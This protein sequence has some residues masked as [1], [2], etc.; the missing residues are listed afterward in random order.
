MKSVIEI[1]DALNLDRRF[2][3][4]L[5]LEWHQSMASFPASGLDFLESEFYAKQLSAAGISVALR[6]LLDDVANQIKSS[7][8]LQ[9]LAWHAHHYLCYSETMPS[10]T[11]WPELE[12]IF[13]FNCGLFYLL[14]GL[15][16]IPVFSRTFRKLGL[17]T[18]CAYNTADWLKGTVEL[19]QSAH[20]GYP[21]H[22]RQ[23]LYWIRNYIQGKLFRIGRF[24]F[25]SQDFPASYGFLVLKNRVSGQVTAI[26]SAGIACSADGMIVYPDQM[27]EN[28][29]FVTSLLR[30]AISVTGHPI[31]PRGFI[32][33]NQVRLAWADWESILQPGDFT[34]GIHI[35]GGGKMTLSSCRDSLQEALAFYR[36]YFP[37]RPVKAFLCD[38]WIFNPDLESLLP[39][40]NLAQLMRQVYLFPVPSTGKDGLFFIF[41]REDGELTDYPRNNSVRRALLSILDAGKRLRSGGM[42]YLPE[43]LEQFGTQYYRTQ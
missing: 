28:T 16:A 40:S 21:G 8:E 26:A 27:P 6:P 41:G 1:L 9:L 36:R 29:F 42:F 24:E 32:C 22:S 4:V 37:E 30:D 35:P 12:S 13:E 18:D 3:P 23:Q 25:M 20:N 38:S 34:P 11:K 5:E 39:E 17:P 14:I 43:H 33:R 10:F 2:A 15:S 7:V 19:Y 31:S